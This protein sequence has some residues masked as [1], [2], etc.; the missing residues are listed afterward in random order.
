MLGVVQ[1]VDPSGVAA[2]AAHGPERNARRLDWRTRPKNDF[3]PF[4]VLLLHLHLLLPP[5]TPDIY[6][7]T[8]QIDP[9]QLSYLLTVSGNPARGGGL[10][11]AEGPT[12]AIPTSDVPTR[13]QLIQLSFIV[14][15]L[16]DSPS[17]ASAC[18]M[19][20]SDRVKRL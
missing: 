19:P 6:F 8:T 3:F 11:L 4:K 5:R 9:V 2:T 1:L 10:F 17:T 20:D 7:R 18:P 14:A 16:T 15:L 13:R 12:A